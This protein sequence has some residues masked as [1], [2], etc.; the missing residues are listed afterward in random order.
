MQVNTETSMST[1]ESCKYKHNLF[2]NLLISPHLANETFPVKREF[3]PYA[4][5]S[6]TGSRQFCEEVGSRLHVLMIIHLIY[7]YPRIIITL[8]SLPYKNIRIV[9]NNEY[10]WTDCFYI[11]T[12]KFLLPLH[13]YSSAW[14]F[15]TFNCLATIN[16]WPWFIQQFQDKTI[17]SYFSTSNNYD[18][19]RD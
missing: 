8:I 4:P 12:L 11:L 13:I 7:Q 15:T 18:C 16:Y 2:Q 3:L 17:P 9:L 10:I 1:L 5:D 6:S 19:Y 14:S